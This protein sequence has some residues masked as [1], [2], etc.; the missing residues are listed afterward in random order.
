MQLELWSARAGG[1]EASEEGR[2]RACVHAH[3]AEL[4]ATPVHIT[5]A[6]DLEAL[7]ARA[8][9]YVRDAKSERTR[10]L[11]RTALRA[12]E[13]WCKDHGVRALP[14][15]RRASRARLAARASQA[16]HASQLAQLAPPK[17]RKSGVACRG[18]A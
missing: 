12:F 5:L 2:A 18:A 3:H 17:P 8:E 7:A 14:A 1:N 10:Q 16:A 4:V 13:R 15:T 11:Y 9:Q 6:R